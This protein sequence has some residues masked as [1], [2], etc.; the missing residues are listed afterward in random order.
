[1]NT[2]REITGKLPEPLAQSL[3][4]LPEGVVQEVEEIRLR[5]GY[6]I[7]LQCGMR[8]RILG[9]PVTQ[10][11]LHKTL[12]NLIQYSYYAYEDDLAKGFVTIEG[13]HRVGIC[14]KAVIR[15]GQ[16][17]LIKEIS[18]LNVRFAKEIKGC[19]RPVIS[20]VIEGKRPVNT[21]I[22]SPPGCGKTTLL[23]DI[24]RVLSENRYKV[25]ICDERSELA[26]MYHARPSFDLGPRC[27]VL[28][29]C[30]K[31]WG[32]PM[33]I[34]SMSPEVIITDEIGKP[35]D[36]SAA[37]Q[38]LVSG[39]TLITS[40]HGNC[41]EDV[42]QSAIGPLIGQGFFRKLIYLTNVSGV[43]T[44]RKVEDG[45]G[46]DGVGEDEGHEDGGREDA[47]VAG[48]R[49]WERA[50]APERDRICSAS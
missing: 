31:A 7:R 30:E 37:R 44:I 1:M 34:R 28:D 32:V 16:P 49:G 47:G 33:L 41:R 27:D 21:L 6:P 35:E 29:G 48:C 36:L 24:A 17:G 2:F 19:S 43:G 50:G 39:V 12:N 25:A 10:E 8:E 40:I 11:D 20:E 3:K 9:Q 15:Q 22:I 5:C 46:K 38:C 18:S 13:G 4:N 14:G 26:G 42:E 23:R 45:V